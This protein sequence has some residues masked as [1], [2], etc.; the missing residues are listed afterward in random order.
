[1][2]QFGLKE[3]NLR[4]RTIAI[5]DIHGCSNALARILLAIE[6]K[7][8]DTIVILGDFIDR[9]TDTNGVIKQLIT[10]HSQCR[11]IAIQGNHEQMMLDALSDR[12]KLERWLRYGKSTLDSYG[13]N[14]SLDSLPSKHIEFVVSTFDYFESR[15]H[16][17]VHATYLPEVS[18]EELSPLFLRW[19]SFNPDCLMPHCSGNTVIAGHT[20]QESGEILDLGFA[21]CIDTGCC[22]NGWLTALDVDN[23]QIW[24]TNE[25]GELRT[26]NR[27]I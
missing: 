25:R 17:F 27:Q 23:G 11:L 24:Q 10:L 16:L 4:G 20:R 18:V 8:H 15:G 6:P 21:V 22:H 14:S 2:E 13:Q 5:G 9:G 7:R 26:S 1:M 12:T 19:E 3:Q